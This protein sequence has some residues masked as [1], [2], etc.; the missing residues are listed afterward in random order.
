M[1]KK[2]K[3]D[4]ISFPTCP[5]ILNHQPRNKTVAGAAPQKITIPR[6]FVKKSVITE[7]YVTGAQRN[8]SPQMWLPPRCQ[9]GPRQAAAQVEETPQGQ[10][11]STAP[12]EIK[13]LWRCSKLRLESS[14]FHS[15]PSREILGFTV[16]THYKTETEV[17]EQ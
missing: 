2:K 9:G 11:Q 17:T 1:P 8:T 6:A 12:R 5:V 14:M 3:K 4:I 16:N 7:I 13:G 10:G 15:A